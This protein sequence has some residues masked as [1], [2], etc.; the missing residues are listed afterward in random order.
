[1]LTHFQLKNYPLKSEK[2]I[3]YFPN[4][5]ESTKAVLCF[6]HRGSSWKC[7]CL[8]LKH[9]IFMFSGT[10][11]RVTMKFISMSLPFSNWKDAD[12]SRDEVETCLFQLHRVLIQVYPSHDRNFVMFWT[13]YTRVNLFWKFCSKERCCGTVETRVTFAYVRI[14]WTGRASRVFCSKQLL[15]CIKLIFGN[16]REWNG[17]IHIICF[18]TA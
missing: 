7:D 10:V 18:V 12:Y 2:L 17:I 8:I 9:G 11:L 6:M 1:M 16:G 5:F 15:K 13:H 3:K 14:Q 4:T